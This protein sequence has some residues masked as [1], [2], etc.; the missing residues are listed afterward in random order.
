M[1]YLK[2]MVVFKIIIEKKSY[3]VLKTQ[4]DILLFFV[5]LS[6]FKKEIC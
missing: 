2:D 3:R 5:L 4:Q 6:V 1:L